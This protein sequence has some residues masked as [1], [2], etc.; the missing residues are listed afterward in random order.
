MKPTDNPISLFSVIPP[1]DPKTP[2]LSIRDLS[3]FYGKKMVFN[4]IDFDL[5]PGEAL[6]IV[7]RAGSGKSTLL[8]CIAG[9][10]P[11]TNGAIGFKASQ[12][13]IDLCR[14]NEATLRRVVH[15]QIGY[16]P[17]NA[18]RQ[19]SMDVTA[20]G[21][22]AQ[23]LLTMGMRHFGTIR[24]MARQWLELFGI[25]PGRMDEMTDTYSGGMLKRL[26]I[27]AVLA[28]TPRLLLLDDPFSGLDRSSKSHIIKVLKKEMAH[29]QLSIILVNRTLKTA[30]L[31]SHKICAI[32]KGRFIHW[33]AEK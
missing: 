1:G 28:F 9:C 30:R 22:I 31:F 26:Q 17:R 29:R 3:K 2:L 4:G 8:Q 13:R 20:G 11:P 12:G 16:V 7:G 10:V 19:L 21:N 32:K 23:G 6:N 24:F 5:A 14:T 33:D 15:S 25:D 27:A 18:H